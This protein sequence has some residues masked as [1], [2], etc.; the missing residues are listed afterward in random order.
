[1]K[2]VRSWTGM[3]TAIFF[4][5]AIAGAGSVLAQA[6]D[7]PAPARTDQETPAPQ[8][9]QEAAPAQ[10]AG[11]RSTQNRLRLQ[12]EAYMGMG[13]DSNKV[14]TTTTGEDVK[15]SGGGG[16]GVGATMGYGI[17]K[18]FDIEGTLGVQ[19]SALHPAVENANGTFSR[20]FLLAT[21]KYKV[22]I[23][24][25]LQWKFGLG[26]GYYMGGKLDIDIDPSVPLGLRTV[27]DYK[28]AVG[29]HATGELEIL[30][31]ERL[32]LSVGLKY[33][34][35]TYKADKVTVNNSSR[36]VSSLSG[37]FRDLKGD[38]IDATVGLAV[39]F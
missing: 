34:N 6:T 4:V 11:P 23:R 35:V 24:E 14:G 3:V 31:Q 30:L 27:V 29:A 22:P 37:E 15:I 36:D 12:I 39:L 19:A 8:D 26:A 17:S 13:L 38:G 5:F 1:M 33:Y 28:N 18:R 20:S 9:R 10:A 16:F 7:P 32:T 2:T 25:N 21:V